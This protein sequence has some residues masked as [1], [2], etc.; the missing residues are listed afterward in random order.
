MTG[1]SMASPYVAGV[2]GL[3][4]AAN[5]DSPPRSAWA[6]CSAR[7]VRCRA[8]RYEWVNDAGFGRIDPEAAVEEARAIKPAR[9]R[10]ASGG[11]DMK[12]TI[13]QSDKGDC[14]LLEGKSGQL[15]LCDGGMRRSMSDACARGAGQAARTSE[16]DLVYVSH[17]DNDHI[18]GV[19]Q[20]LEDEASGAR[21]ITTAKRPD[22]ASSRSSL[23]RRRS[24]ASC[25]TPSVTGVA[26]QQVDWPT[27]SSTAAPAL[28]RPPCRRWRWPPTR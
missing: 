5:R 6:S 18:S 7:R 22:G 8:P 16:I 11:A 14:L 10:S 20:L 19:L 15:M 27:C 1:T 26:E 28:S 24:R 2:V 12:L 3:M 9:R 4:L 21:S 25:T 13:F 23:A 17:I